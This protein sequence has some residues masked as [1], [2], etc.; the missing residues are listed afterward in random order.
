[1]M[2]TYEMLGRSVKAAAIA[3]VLKGAGISGSM[4]RECVPLMTKVQWEGICFHAK[5][6]YRKPPS[7]LTIAAVAD[8]LDGV[9]DG[10][11]PIM[12]GNEEESNA[13]RTE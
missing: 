6:G 8:I 13:Q 5:V 3:E 4:L 11:P 10:P 2:T 1:M 7:A 9:Q 12:W